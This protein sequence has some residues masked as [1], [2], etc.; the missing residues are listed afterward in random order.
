MALHSIFMFRN[1]KRRRATRPSRLDAQ[2][3]CI[4]SFIYDEGNRRDTDQCDSSQAN[5]YDATIYR[6]ATTPAELELHTVP[7]T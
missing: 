4:Y 5:I 6:T 3:F 7:A 2:D 1:I